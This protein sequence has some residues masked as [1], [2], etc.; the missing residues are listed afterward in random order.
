MN[1][2]TQPSTN[3]TTSLEERLNNPETAE[4]LHRLLDRLDTIEEA[5]ERLEALTAQGPAM[6]AMMT[7]MADDVYHTAEEAG[8]DLD[9]RLRLALQ[10]AERLTA[11]RTVAVL[12]TLTDR[13]DQLEQL[14]AMADQAPGF[15][16][17]A[18]DM[19]DD[20]Y[21]AAE[22]AGHDPEQMLRRSLTALSTLLQSG[23]L[24][25]EAVDLAGQAGD[26]LAA[27]REE[28]PE[29]G[30]L[31]LLRALRDP[32]VQRALGFFTAFSKQFGRRLRS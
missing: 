32:D 16:A 28:T 25:P 2:T 5:V 24:A 10:L 30:L 6:A 3:G 12:T 13:M 18:A 14:I 4:A 20:V 23:L 8:I 15:V 22:E 11:P 19:F 9:E 17:M 29:V 27:S 26:A 1:Q 21:R 7:D 31:G